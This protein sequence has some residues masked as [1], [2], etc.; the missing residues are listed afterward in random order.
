M[1]FASKHYPFDKSKF[2]PEKGIGFPADF[3]AEGQDQ[4]R[5]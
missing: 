5:G 3:I 2:N 1:P 4:T